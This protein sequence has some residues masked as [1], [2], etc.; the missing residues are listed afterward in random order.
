M[1]ALLLNWARM[2]GHEFRSTTPGRRGLTALHL[3]ALVRDNGLTAALLTAGCPDALHGWEGSRSEDGSTPLGLATRYGTAAELERILAEA[4][5]ASMQVKG[6]GSAFATLAGKGDPIPESSSSHLLEKRGL[7]IERYPSELDDVAMA[8]AAQKGNNLAEAAVSSPL[9]TFASPTLEAK[10]ATWYH[11]GQV[12]VDIAFMMIT[13]LSQMAWVLRWKL[14]HSVVL[15]GVMLALIAFNTIYLSLATLRPKTYVSRREWLCVASLMIHKLA[16]MMVT[17]LPG[18][19]T[20]YSP[21]YNTTVALLESSSFAQI[22]MLSFGAR[23]R[24]AYFLPTL[25]AMLP[26]SATINGSICRAAFP[27]ASTA[28]CGVGMFAFQVAACCALP[29]AAAYMSEQRSRKI[30]LRTAVA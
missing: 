15:G 8:K 12:P 13:I 7:S 25:M 5:Y 1:L 20:I 27:G 14:S 9:L 23:G 11:T 16:Q 10:Y 30:F 28:M 29:A 18:V 6:G 21:T 3:G 2:V 26:L 22:A 4:Q 17:A 24:F 19:G